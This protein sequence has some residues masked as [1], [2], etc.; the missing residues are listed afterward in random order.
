MKHLQYC[1]IHN[2]EELNMAVRGLLPMQ[3]TDL[4]RDGIF[5]LVLSWHKCINISESCGKE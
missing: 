1:Q 2:N 5:K 3:E 4:Y